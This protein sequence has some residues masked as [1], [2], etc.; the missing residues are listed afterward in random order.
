MTYFTASQT[1]SHS[2]KVSQETHDIKVPGLRLRTR[3]STQTWCLVKKMNGRFIRHTIGRYPEISRQNARKRALMILGDINMGR[4][5]PK[6]DL[7][8]L[9]LTLQDAFEGYLRLK[10][11]RLKPSTITS[12]TNDFNGTFKSW[13]KRPIADLTPDVVVQLHKKRSF[14]SKARADGAMRLLRALFNY[15]NEMSDDPKKLPDPTKKLNKHRLWNNVPRRKTF[16]SLEQ[17]PDFIRG[18][19]EDT[20][21]TSAD[22]VLLLLLTGCRLNEVL[23]LRWR[24]VN[25]VQNTFSIP[26][27]KSGRPITLPLNRHAAQILQIRHSQV[28]SS[29]FVF[30]KGKSHLKSVRKCLSRH[31]SDLTAHDLRR[32]FLTVGDGIGIGHYMLK[33]LVNHMPSKSDVTAGYISSDIELMRQASNRIADMLISGNPDR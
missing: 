18:L 19:K 32:T 2:T 9:N 31:A 5:K 30:A 6:K 20:N 22:A 17:T 3:G 23:G 4:Y 27:N 28:E 7:R 21:R 29:D 14:D 24:Q 11:G 25:L 33:L 15:V 10:Q 1:S 12:Y 26:E 8:P 16:L 13:S